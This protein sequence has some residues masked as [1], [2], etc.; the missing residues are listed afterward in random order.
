MFMLMLR[1]GLRVEEVAHLFLGNIDLKRR[2]L[3][4]QDGKG[5]KDR[6]AYISN[7]A[8]G[9]LV[10]YLRVRPAAEGQESLP[11]GE[12]TVNRS[13]HIRS[14]ASRSAWSIMPKNTNMK[15]SCHHLRHTMATQML[16]ADADLSTIQDLLGH[17]SIR[18]T[19]RYCRISNLKV[20]R[21]YYKAMEVIMQRTAGNPNDT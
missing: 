20:Q 21:D 9:A 15:I 16:N 8:L 10:E 3:L 4:I 19:Q 11:R 7:D 17:N 6:V 18:T 14:A 1:C 5:A 13:A 2:M 12:R